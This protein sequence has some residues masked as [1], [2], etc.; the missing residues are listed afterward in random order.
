MAPEIPW[1]KIVGSRHILVH[2]YF[3]IDLDVV[4]N[5]VELELP[6]LRRQTERLLS[7]LDSNV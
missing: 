3:G 2:D 5:V 6:E 4:W 7:R 1:R